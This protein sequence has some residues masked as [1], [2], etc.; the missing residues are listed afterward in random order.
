MKSAITAS[1]PTII[2][3]LNVTLILLSLQ[4]N[5]PPLRLILTSLA[6]TA[7]LVFFQFALVFNFLDKLR[8]R[9]KG[10]TG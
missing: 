9:I 6:S 8:R 4:Y 1:V 2:A 7:V 3:I 10:G 5:W